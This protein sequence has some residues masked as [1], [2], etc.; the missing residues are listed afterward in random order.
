MTRTR[1]YK[2]RTDKM[3]FGV[4]GGLADYF[5]VDPVLVRIAFVVLT[6]AG[7]SGI[8]LYLILAILM[9]QQETSAVAPGDIVREN[10]QS[11]TAEAA[12][13]GRR[14][15][16]T[17]SGA[18]GRETARPPETA[19]PDERRNTLAVILIGV[20]VLLLLANLGLFSW[21]DWDTFWPVLLI[22][23][24]VAVIVGRFGRG[25]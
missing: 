16:E 8:L 3:V 22:L 18:L 6:V 5:N 24:G 19:V 23:L 11:I 13:A 4:C 20:G 10:L 1:L 9:P 2:S 14:G 12:E 7:G 17:V 25:S 15:V 21:F